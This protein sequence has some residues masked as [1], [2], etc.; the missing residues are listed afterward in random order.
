MMAGAWDLDLCLIT[1]LLAYLCVQN[2]V[3]NEFQF[4]V[5]AVFVH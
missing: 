3:S 4:V 2:E 1:T 5:V